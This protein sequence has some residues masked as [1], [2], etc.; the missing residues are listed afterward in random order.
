MVREKGRK[1]EIYDE[2]PENRSELI[3]YAVCT[4][5]GSKPVYISNGMFK[6]LNLAVGLVL[7]LTM[8]HR[9]PEPL[10]LADK[11]SRERLN[12]MFR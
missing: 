8:E 4:H 1:I 12:D 7:E 6:N 5:N 3:G 11:V 10:Y 9:L 2:D